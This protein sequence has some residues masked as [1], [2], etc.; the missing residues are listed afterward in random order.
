VIVELTLEETINAGTVGLLRQAENLS[1]NRANKHKASKDAWN[2][3]ING[4]IAEF[5]FAKAMG[6]DW[7]GAHDFKGRDVGKEWEVR[8]TAYQKGKLILHKDDSDDAK[9]ALVIWTGG[10]TWNIAGWIRGE[11]G[12]LPE[13]WCDPQSA[14]RWCYMVPQSVLTPILVPTA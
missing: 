7:S 9:F 6:L 12:K 10:F 5:V 8:S 1:V 4:A 2:L 13:Y 3:H 14:N 11:S